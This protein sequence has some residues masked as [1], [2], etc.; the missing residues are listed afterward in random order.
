[1]GWYRVFLDEHQVAG[2]ELDCL[3][4]QFEAIFERGGSKDMALFSTPHPEHGMDCYFSPDCLPPARGL[5]EY[6]KGEP[7]DPPV[8][9][10][11]H[12]VV[13]HKGVRERLLPH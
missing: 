11:L 7:C 4:R 1:M 6:Y 3:A 12:T 10:E 13:G 5:I 8:D 9:R 2:D